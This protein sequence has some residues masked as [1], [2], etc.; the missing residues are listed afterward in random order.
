MTRSTIDQYHEEKLA[1]SRFNIAAILQSDDVGK[2]V[3]R[4]LRRAF[5]SLKPDLERLHQVIT[6]DVLKREVVQ[7]EEANV[8]EQAWDA[9]DRRPQTQSRRRF[10]PPIAPPISMDTG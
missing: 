9:K 10:Q 6:N 7:G 4:E 3:R 2:I 1:M 5:P 8:A